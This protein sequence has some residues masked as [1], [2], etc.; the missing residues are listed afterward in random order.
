MGSV[1]AAVLLWLARAYSASPCYAELEMVCSLAMVVEY[2]IGTA[3]PDERGWHWV[4]FMLLW[5]VGTYSASRFYA[6]V[7]VLSRDG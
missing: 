1:Y 3:P 5:L 7:V 2:C 6:E 4:L